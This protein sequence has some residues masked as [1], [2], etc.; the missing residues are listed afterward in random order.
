MKMLHENMADPRALIKQ[1]KE[2]LTDIDGNVYHLLALGGQVWIAENLNVTHYAN[3]DPIPMIT[4]N[5]DWS[6]QTA[7]AFCNNLNDA[8]RAKTYGRLYNRLAVMDGRKLCPNGWHVPSYAE[9]LSLMNC[10]GGEDLAGQAMR[11]ISTGHV[12]VSLGGYRDKFGNFIRPGHSGQY[13]WSDQPENEMIVGLMVD[14]K[15]S[16]INYLN[17]EAVE[18]SGMSVRCIRDF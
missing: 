2:T 3:G 5:A 16:K 15:S 4:R 9:W 18:N 1:L 7:G 17:S 11:G 8:G 13:W 12:F 14:E 10:F 6:S